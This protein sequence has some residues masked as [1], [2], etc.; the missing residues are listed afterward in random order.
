MSENEIEVEIDYENFLKKFGDNPDGIT[1][2]MR[3]IYEAM[4]KDG[5]V[6]RMGDLLKKYRGRKAASSA[7]KDG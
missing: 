6:S 2:E 5:T 1:P 3:R 7:E 4:K